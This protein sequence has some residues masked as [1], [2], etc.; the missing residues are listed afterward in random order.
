MSF[1]GFGTGHVFHSADAG[2]TW[3]D[4]SGDLPD[5]PI[6]RVVVDP[7]NPYGAYVG[8]DLRVFTTTD[9]GAVWGHLNSG[10]PTAQVLDLIINPSAGKMRA[11]TFGNGVYEIDLRNALR[12]LLLRR[13]LH[14]KLDHRR[15]GM[16]THQEGRLGKGQSTATHRGPSRSAGPDPESCYL[17]DPVSPGPHRTRDRGNPDRLRVATRLATAPDPQP[18]TTVA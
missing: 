4:R 13:S 7:R 3:T 14:G 11:A 5:V 17:P 9:G 8:T 16:S 12:N 1:S 18:S 2:L 6:Q 15:D 10:I